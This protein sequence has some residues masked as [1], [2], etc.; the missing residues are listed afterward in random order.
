M[1]LN[2][3]LFKEKFGDKVR[4]HLASQRTGAM[5]ETVLAMRQNSALP[6]TCRA[7][8][9]LPPPKVKPDSK[10][11][12]LQCHSKDR[13]NS[14]GKPEQPCRAC[15]RA[16]NEASVSPK[17]GPR[18]G[19]WCPTAHT[20]FDASRDP[21]GQTQETPAQDLFELERVAVAKS[22]LQEDVRG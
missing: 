13:L 16:S 22:R 1:R 10:W 20:S 4:R 12:A 17:Q 11:P 9:R 6:C 18:A 7:V 19:T 5:W 15:W 2:E 21:G 8:S 3:T 14:S